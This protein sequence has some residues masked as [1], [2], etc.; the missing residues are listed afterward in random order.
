MPID[1]VK[2]MTMEAGLGREKTGGI[3]SGRLLGSLESEVMSHMWRLKQ[4]TVRQVVSIINRER[5]CAYT[6]VM[7]VMCHLVD[8]GLLARH[9][10]GKRYR[11][12]VAQSEDEFLRAR[13]QE[14]VRS[15]L[16]DYGDLAIAGFL[17]EIGKAKPEKLAELREMLSKAADEDAS[18]R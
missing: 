14:K 3:G 1:E 2:T 18:S 10:E 7:T 13:S 4:A 11:Y 9:S 5:E 17:G 8:K 15:L 6:T 12:S 16:S